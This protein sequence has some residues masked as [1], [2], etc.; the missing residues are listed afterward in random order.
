VAAAIS[1]PRKPGFVAA[2]FVKR[3]SVILLVSLSENA[4][5]LT[6]NPRPKSNVRSGRAGRESG[7]AASRP[8]Q[9]FAGR[10]PAAAL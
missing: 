2:H 3:R 7:R 4:C 1:I 10:C 5:P 9:L 8:S 6:A